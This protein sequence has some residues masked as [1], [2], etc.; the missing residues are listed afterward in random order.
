MEFL[1]LLTA[2]LYSSSALGN[3]TGH[4]I[5]MEPTVLPDGALLLDGALSQRQVSSLF[6]GV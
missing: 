3:A 5:S 4:H 2:L 6:L 1:E